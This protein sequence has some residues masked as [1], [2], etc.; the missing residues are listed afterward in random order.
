MF[1]LPITI[2]PARFS[3]STLT[4]SFFGMRFLKCSN[5]A[6]VPTPASPAPLA[7]FF[8]GRLRCLQR[9]RGADGDERV[10][11]RLKAFDAIETRP[12]HFHR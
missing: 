9:R 8:L 1:V 4:A 6:V 5:A 11:P 7:D 3:F 10:Q 12:H 2:A